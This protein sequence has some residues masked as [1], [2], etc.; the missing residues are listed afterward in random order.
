MI[1]NDSMKLNSLSKNY[2]NRFTPI[3]D[4]NIFKQKA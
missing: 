2:I 4:I 3:T 1:D